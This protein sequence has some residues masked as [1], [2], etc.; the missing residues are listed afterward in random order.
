MCFGDIGTGLQSM[1]YGTGRKGLE[2]RFQHF[3]VL[4]PDVLRGWYLNLTVW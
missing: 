2:V 1:G 3:P 4:N